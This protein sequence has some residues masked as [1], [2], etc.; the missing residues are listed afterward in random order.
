MIE[1]NNFITKEDYLVMYN[2][3]ALGGSKQFPVL[4]KTW[5]LMCH[6]YHSLSLDATIMVSKNCP[7][8]DEHVGVIFLTQ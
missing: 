6:Y 7:I 4:S 1:G 8:T 5:I 2:H 3:A